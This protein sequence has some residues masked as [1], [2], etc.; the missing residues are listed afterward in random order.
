[1]RFGFPF[2]NNNMN[3]LF[4]ILN[5]HFSNGHTMKAGL[6]LREERALNYWYDHISS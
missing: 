2:V 5:M 1:M 3:V 4:E 6:L